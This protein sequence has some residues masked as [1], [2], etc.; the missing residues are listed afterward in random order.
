MKNNSNFHTTEKFSLLQLEFNNDTD[1]EY[2]GFCHKDK[3]YLK[4][5]EIF[6]RNN[7]IDGFNVIT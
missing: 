6:R 5:A 2:F 3:I 7:N 4:L 1:S